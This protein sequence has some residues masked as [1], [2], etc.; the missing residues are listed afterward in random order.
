MTSPIFIS[1]RVLDT[2]NSLPD[3]DRKAIAGAI[4]GELILGSDATSELTPMQS[5]VFAIIRQYVTHD[6]NNLQ[7]RR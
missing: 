3:T 1:P 4:A 7:F 6:T 5:L 2:I